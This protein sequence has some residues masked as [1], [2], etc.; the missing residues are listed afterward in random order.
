M[1]EYLR[2]ERLGQA[3]AA[4]SAERLTIVAGGTDVYPARVG[5]PLDDDVLDVTAI[6]GLGDIEDQGDCWRIGALVTWSDVIAAELPPCF[7]G[8]K[9]AAREVGGRQIQNVA[10]VAGNLCNASPAADGAPN[11]LALDAV[12]ELASAAGERSVAIADFITGNRLT[13]RRADEMVVAIRV[14]KP[15]PGCAGIFLKLGARAYLVISIVMVA[16]VIEPKDGLVGGVRIAVG[17]CAPVSR[18]LPALEA[19]LVGAPLHAA[20]GEAADAS[21]LDGILA[22]IDDVRGSAGYRRDA[23]LTLVRRGLGELGARL[24]GAS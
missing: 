3:L 23:A 14:P 6:A 13:D 4:L 21:H 10:T 19:L 2:P 7:D 17:A 11:L 5:R 20:L 1:A 18:R 22:P 8:L 16:I 15:A 24:G 12:V 9:R